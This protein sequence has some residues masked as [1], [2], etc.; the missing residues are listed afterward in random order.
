MRLFRGIA[1]QHFLVFARR[2]AQMCKDHDSRLEAPI[3]LTDVWSE[4]RMSLEALLQPLN[5]L[6]L[7]PNG[8]QRITWVGDLQQGDGGKGA[9]VD[10]LAAHHHVVARVQGGDNAGHTA[11]F[12]HDGHEVVTKVHLLPSGLRHSATIGVLANG[13][14]VNAEQ[15]NHDLEEFSLVSPSVVDRLYI[16][17]RAHLVLP[18]HI[19]VDKLQEDQKTASGSEI[20][21][22]RR[23]IGPANL[24]KVN[25]IGLRV[26]DLRR[27]STVAQRIRQNVDFFR[28]DEKE[29]DRNIEW[30]ETYQ[31]VLVDR[32]I[33]SVRFL[34]EAASAGYSILFEGAQGPLIDTEQ[35]LYPYVTT[36]P[37]AFYSVAPGAGFD[38]C[39]VKHRI[40][41]LKAYQTMVG[42]GAFISEDHGAIGERLRAQGNEFGT[43]TGRPRRCGWVDLVHARWAV[44]INNYSCI[45]LTKID[46]LSGFDEIGMCVA[47]EHDGGRIFNF[48][49]EHEFLLECRP[50][51]HFMAGWH[52]VTGTVKSYEDLPAEVHQFVEYVSA[53]LGVDVAGVTVGP[54]DEDFLPRAAYRD[55]DPFAP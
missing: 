30:V 6:G 16:S 22:T 12:V 51:Y 42:N 19:Q 14:L 20:G 4:R 1:E 46:V 32:A 15:L 25:R 11:V 26:R 54:R 28:L 50:V 39:L 48:M 41:V 5:T 34:S 36:S 49:P 24:S 9:M 45:V 21:T 23:G 29:I 13:V 27:T 40:G 3:R 37:T 2:E 10:R 52:G 44:E 43:T 53:Y 55:R 47:Y 33:D 18:L 8:R 7:K 31:S 35:G 17:D 38:T